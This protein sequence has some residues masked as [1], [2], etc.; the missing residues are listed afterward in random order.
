MEKNQF[1]AIEM[2]PEMELEFAEL[3]D[4]DFVRLARAA[5]RLRMA[6]RQKLYQLRSL[7][8]K[9]RRLA[10]NGWTVEKIRRLMESLDDEEETS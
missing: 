2:T 6:K 4:S 9:G 5:D 1:A 3:K 8:R 7:D 10:E